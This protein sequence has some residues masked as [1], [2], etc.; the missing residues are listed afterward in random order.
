MA[1]EI[2]EITTLAAC[3]FSR[4]T[5]NRVKAG[6]IKDVIVLANFL[7]QCQDIAKDE[8]KI[9]I[10][11]GRSEFIKA[12]DTEENPKALSDM[13]VGI[14]GALAIKDWL[15]THHNEGSDPTIKK[16]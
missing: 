1:Y 4:G 8:K 15:G 7:K 5:L 10:V 16:G 11:S 2:S 6:A 12:M 14:S 13:A 9:H 3:F